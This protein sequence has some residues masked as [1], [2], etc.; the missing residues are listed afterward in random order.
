MVQKSDKSTVTYIVTCVCV[1]V[2]VCV[3]LRVNHYDVVRLDIMV[4]PDLSCERY[5]MPRSSGKPF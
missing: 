3:C 1:C 2:C 4:D 5:Y